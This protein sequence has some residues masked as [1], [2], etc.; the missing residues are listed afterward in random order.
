[1]REHRGLEYKR[2][3][4][5]LCERMLTRA[6]ERE[7]VVVRGQEGMSSLVFAFEDPDGTIAPSLITTR[8]LFCF[9][10]HVMVRC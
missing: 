7:M 5:S 4:S 8:H 9:R 1:M 10:A 2:S 3:W 6:V